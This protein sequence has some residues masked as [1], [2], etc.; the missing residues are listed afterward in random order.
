MILQVGLEDLDGLS[1]RS[2]EYTETP[3]LRIPGRA[4]TGY[5]EAHGHLLVIGGVFSRATTVITHIRGRT[6]PL[7]TTQLGPYRSSTCSDVPSLVNTRLWFPLA[8]HENRS[9]AAPMGFT[10]QYGSFRK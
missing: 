6:T 4:L 9:P 5:L 7:E 2:S 10:R 8:Q 3:Q 1:S